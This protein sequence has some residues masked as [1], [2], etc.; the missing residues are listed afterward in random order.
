[1][2]VHISESQELQKTNPLPALVSILLARCLPTQICGGERA[3]TVQ[4]SSKN[5]NQGRI[6]SPSFPSVPRTQLGEL[7][8]N[9]YNFNQFL[10]WAGSP[11]HIPGSK[12]EAF[13]RNRNLFYVTRSRPRRRLALLFTQ[14]LTPPAMATL[15]NW[16]GAGAI[17]ELRISN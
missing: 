14:E 7:L 9:Q 10:E 8:S 6:V 12:R 13:E 17:Q 5:F 4:S 16:F 11:N 1:L 2:G 3:A 15:S